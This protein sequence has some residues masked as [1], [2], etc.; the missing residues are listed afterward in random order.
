MVPPVSDSRWRS[1]VTGSAPF[2]PTMLASQILMKRLRV[3]VQQDP[4]P[5]NV[6]RATTDLKAFFDKYEKIAAGDLAQIFG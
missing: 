3:S 4:S 2:Q 5:A 1:V 6:L